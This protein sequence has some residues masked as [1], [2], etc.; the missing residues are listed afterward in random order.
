MTSDLVR[1]SDAERESVAE[2]LRKA[3]AEGRLDTAELEERVARCYAAKTRAE[4]EP[5][6]ADL[7]GGRLGPRGRTPR[8]FVFPPLVLVALLF[9]AFA[10]FGAGHY[11]LPLVPI[12][13]FVF[14]RFGR[15]RS[16]R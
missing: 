14:F 3:H 13:F 11:P 1:V 10:V 5:L 6:V 4:L 15:R 16:Y 2:R 9:A 7:P 8:A 12:L